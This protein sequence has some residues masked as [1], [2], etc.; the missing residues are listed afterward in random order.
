M[1]LYSLGEEVKGGRGKF[2]KLLLGSCR[3]FKGVTGVRHFSV[4]CLDSEIIF[5]LLVE[6]S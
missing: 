5:R 3:Y 2:L 6:D 4:Y 1:L